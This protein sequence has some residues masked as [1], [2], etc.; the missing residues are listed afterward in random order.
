MAIFLNDLLETRRVRVAPTK[1]VGAPGTA[2]YGG[3]IQEIEKNPKLAGREKYR[4]YS[5]ILANTAIVAAGVRYF[6]NLAAKATWRVEPADDSS[7]A[8]EFAEQLENMM[9]DM[10]TPWHRVVRRAAMYRFYGFSIQEWTA[11]RNEDGTIGIMDIEPRPQITIERWDT[12][13]SGTVQGVIQRSPQSQEELYLPR[14]KLVYV[15]DDTLNDSPEGLGLFRHIVD[16]AK[17]LSR[18]EQ[19]EGFGFETDLRGVPVGRAPFAELQKAVDDNLITPE[20]KRAAEKPVFDFVKGHIKSPSLGIVLDS[21]TYQGEDEA[22]TPS[23]VPL[24]DL[25]LLK[26]SSTS[27]KEVAETISRLNQEIARVLGVEGLL[28]GST[29]HGSQALSTDKSHN[30]AL[31][32]DSTLT[33]L[34]ESFEKDFIDT[35]WSLNGYPE[36]FKPTFK[37]EPVQYR[38]ITQITTALRDLASA[39]AVIDIDD[40]IINEIR[41]LLGFSDQPEREGMAEDSALSQETE[42]AVEEVNEMVIDDEGV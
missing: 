3:Y 34:K 9:Q 8:E 26:S 40:P 32:V 30:F 36:E 24:W 27:Q 4:T 41:D 16:S 17:R 6:L 19:L 33:E 28:L 38:D 35:V 23:S 2:I 7:Q 1:T 22:A 37:I 11:K 20:Q 14:Q 31:I 15:V 13:P 42:V 29:N 5:D 21:L 10:T 25:D 12:D 39:G 18:F